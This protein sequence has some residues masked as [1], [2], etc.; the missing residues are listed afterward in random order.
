MQTETR[1][2]WPGGITCALGTRL[3]KAIAR[4][5]S[6]AVVRFATDEILLAPAWSASDTALRD[7]IALLRQLTERE[8]TAEAARAAMRNVTTRLAGR[9]K[10]A[11]AQAIQ[12]IPKAATAHDVLALRLA[13][14]RLHDTLTR[15]AA[16]LEEGGLDAGI[17]SA[18]GQRDLDVVVCTRLLELRVDLARSL[19]DELRA[20]GAPGAAAPT[21][22]NRAG[23]GHRDAAGGGRDAAASQRPA[24]RL[25]AP[26]AARGRSGR[27]Y[28]VTA[29]DGGIDLESVAGAKAANLAE[30]ARVLGEKAVPAWFAVTDGAFQEVLDSPASAADGAPTLRAAIASILRDAAAT[31]A[32][33]AVAIRTLFEA[34]DAPA[35]AR[36]PR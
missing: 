17:I 31:S 13:V 21:A 27:R 3:E 22:A 29:R 2:S 20:G 26:G 18:S 16:A 34:S 7:G 24:G 10:E 4:V 36:R 32:A 35:T 28:V 25:G 6:P 9:V 11:R 30:A 8:A 15:I 19:G 12:H 1:C 5:S 23:A 14:L 33:R